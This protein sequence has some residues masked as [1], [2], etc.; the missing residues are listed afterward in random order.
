MSETK[1]FNRYSK[2]KI[3]R[4]INDIDP[5]EIYIGST[6]LDLSK[7]LFNHRA[8]AR[9]NK[10]SKI[11]Q[12]MKDVGI[13]HF[14]IVLVEEYPCENKM[15]LVQ[16]EQYYIDLLKPN[17]NSRWAYA[18][19]EQKKDRKNDHQKNHYQN[20][21]DAKLASNRNYRLANI[22]L[23]SANASEKV[24]CECGAIIRKDGL[25]RHRNTQP[26]L[27]YMK[28]KEEKKEEAK[29]EKPIETKKDLPKFTAEDCELFF[30][31]INSI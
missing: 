31:L 13:D 10:K 1:E 9:L 2:G 22:R 3:Y 25:S 29:V 20:N 15:Q 19:D 8:Y 7:R 27:Q 28:S 18:T 14:K 6:C 26:H 21:R 17:L 30:S 16:R 23:I 4:L 24:T 12:R 5:N 11:Y